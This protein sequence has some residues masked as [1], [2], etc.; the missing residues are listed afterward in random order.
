M[1]GLS[2]FVH[3]H[4]L[5]EE[6]NHSVSMLYEGGNKVLRLPNEAYLLRS[7]DQL[8]VQL[9]TLE[10]AR[11]SISGPPCTRGR[12]RVLLAGW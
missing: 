12:A 4:V 8:I 5:H 2:H 10:N 7:C 1:L 3:V 6:P 9:N 11:R